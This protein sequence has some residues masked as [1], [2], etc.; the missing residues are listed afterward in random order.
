M[1]YIDLAHDT[2]MWRVVMNSVMNLGSHKIRG[3]YWVVHEP[4]AFQ[5][6]LCSLKLVIGKIHVQLYLQQTMIAFVK[7]KTSLIFFFS[8]ES[9]SLIAAVIVDV[10]NCSPRL[11]TVMSHS[12]CKMCLMPELYAA[13]THVGKK[14]TDNESGLSRLDLRFVLRFF[15]T[16]MSLSHGHQWLSL[17][18]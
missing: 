13:L 15:T 5:K 1:D 18:I 9:S 17:G 2:D 14:W 4:L 12:V 6:G 11:K 3:I 8:S 16:S 7:M 10:A